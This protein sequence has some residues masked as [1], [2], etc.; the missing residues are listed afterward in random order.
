MGRR[1]AL[2]NFDEIIVIFVRRKHG[3]FI[4]F[5]IMNQYKHI[6]QS[7]YYYNFIY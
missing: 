2:S 6:K 3:I 5:I 1:R 7:F 4:I